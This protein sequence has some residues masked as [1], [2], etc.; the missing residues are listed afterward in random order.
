M[1]VEYFGAAWCPACT[2]KWPLV[3][4]TCK[5]FGV[6]LVRY[7]LDLDPGAHERAIAL[8][9]KSVPGVYISDGDRKVW[10]GIGG[11]INRGTLE[12]FLRKE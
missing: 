7:D 4:Q 10:S 1:R 2:V 8:G 5:E 11:F 9:L 3:D 6:E 12:T